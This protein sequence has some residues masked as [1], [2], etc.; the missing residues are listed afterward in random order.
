MKKILGFLRNPLLLS[1]LGVTALALLVWFIGPLVAVAGY[2]PLAPELNRAIAIGAILALWALNRLRIFLASRRRNSEIIDGLASSSAAP[3]DAAG[4]E[5]AEEIALI[6]QR[7]E[8]ALDLLKKA[9]LDHRHGR[10]FLYQLPW[11]LIIGPPGS[12]KTTALVNSGLRFPLAEQL[13]ADAVR[14]IG[15]TRNCD[16]WFTDEAVLLDTAG[17]YTTQDSYEEVDRAAWT[18]FLELLKK[19]RR[20]RPINGVLVAI[21]VA[22]LLRQTEAERAAHARAIKRRIQELHQHFG[23]R[24][25][26]YLLFTKCDLIAGFMEFFA[27]LGRGERAQVLG[28]T[29]PLDEEEA[30][31]GAAGRFSTEFDL[32]LQSLNHRLLERLQEERDPQR[33]S[34]IYTF[35]QQFAALKDIADPFIAEIF[36]PSRFEEHPMLRGIYFTSGTQ[37][38]SPIDR[39]MGAVATTFG[40]D[41]QALPAFAGQGKSFFITRLLREVIFQ[42]AGLAGTNLR[43]ERQRA[44]LQGGAYAATLAL[45]ALAA[46]AWFTSYTR[47]QGYIK[48]VQ[49]QVDTA[50]KQIEGIVP[51]QRDLL[52]ILPVLNM[53]RDLPGSYG[54]QDYSRPWLMGLGL[55]QGDKLG[56][57]ARSVYQRLLVRAFLPR[58][59]LRLEDQLRE[60]SGNPDF[61]YE[62]L[63]VYLMLDDRDHFDA[64]TVQAW[65][66]LDW[67][68]NLPRDIPTRQRRQL[69]AHLGALLESEFHPLPIALD[70][71]LISQARGILKRIPLEQR[72]Y[73]QLKQ[74]DL[75]KGIPDFLIS[76]AAGPDAPQVFVRKSGKPLNQGIPGLYTYDGYHKAFLREGP[77]LIASLA[78]E[79]W[80]LGIHKEISPESE[81]LQELIG[82]VRKRYLDDYVR[83]WEELLADIKIIPFT[84]LRQGVEVLRILSG[85]DSPIKKLLVAVERE[86][87]LIRPRDGGAAMLEQAGAKISS[88]RNRLEGLFGEAAKTL[89]DAALARPEQAVAKRFEALN[90]QV[91]QPADGPPPLEK[92]LAL[93]NELF[94]YLNSVAS[95]ADRGGAALEAAKTQARAGSDLMVRL[96]AGAKRQP[97]PIRGWLQSVARGTSS[98]FLSDVRT[99]LN[100][101][102][103][104]TVLPFCNK[105]LSKRYPLDRTSRREATLEDFGRFFGPNGLMDEFFQQYLQPFVDSSGPTWRWRRSLG[106]P[107]RVLREFQHAASIRETF[108]RGDGQRPAITFE[109]LPLRLDANITQF[110]LD[111]EG[112]KLEYRHGPTRLSKLQWPGPEPAGG[113]RLVF[114]DINGNRYSIARDGPWA[115]F[116]I[117]DD[118]TLEATD[119]PDRFH[120]TFNVKSHK[121]SYELR[122]SSSVLNPFRPGTLREFNCP[123]RL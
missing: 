47:N 19:Y 41:R 91:Q 96:G 122:L 6:K 4:M 15:G 2:E 53:V 106:I 118:A 123:G 50:Q 80:V 99:Q 9:R 62:A 1:L 7:F 10:N 94:I 51:G 65:M 57:Q 120:V 82:N 46:A 60:G 23:I 105:A 75:G 111:L 55:Y 119:R 54:S 85:P 17:R 18:G 89:P 78:S 56:A 86:T 113:V 33:R 34:L 29:F 76:K 69:Q 44:W 5:S 45:T 116:R 30:R 36:Q 43:L 22:D 3:L 32:L 31:Q 59:I 88:I 84:S 102:W 117:L 101:V 92:T 61:L 114:V 21:S 103:N 115:W 104:S 25:P 20:R 71:D 98:L 49:A 58:I 64:K 24:F 100:A 27:N 38:G 79:S 77:A 107:N 16:W 66:A 95:A 39:I 70:E 81:G 13:G 8:E 26:V 121:A 28:M 72:I 11:Y 37:E 14:G 97:K 67:E 40:L 109:L 110:L 74:A 52:A 12:G 63:K 87:N 48:E 108:F 68:H 73:V 93:L 112:Q 83:Q 42:E 90:R 35:P